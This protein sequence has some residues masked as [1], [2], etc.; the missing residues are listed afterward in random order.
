MS[1]LVWTEQDMKFILVH[2][3]SNPPRLH[4]CYH[5]QMMFL[6]GLAEPVNSRYVRFI[7]GCVNRYT[8]QRWLVYRLTQPIINLTYLATCMN[9]ER[10]FL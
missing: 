3:R 2:P 9:I 1:E 4:Y 6:P 10:N 8:N 5:S 7:I